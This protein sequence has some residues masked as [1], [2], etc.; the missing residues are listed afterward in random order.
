MRLYNISLNA[1]VLQFDPRLTAMGPGGPPPAY[2]MYPIILPLA[3][4]HWGA[5][6]EALLPSPPSSRRPRQSSSSWSASSG[7]NGRG[8]FLCVVFDL[9]SIRTS[10]WTLTVR[11][12]SFYILIHFQ[13]NI[14]TTSGR[15]PRLHTAESSL[16]LGFLYVYSLYYYTVLTGLWVHRI[17]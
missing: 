14:Q 1:P 17:N 9:F 6:A 8:F 11:Q 10:G 12:W 15:N 4:H 3:P 2:A 7:S 16:A 13:R 5:P